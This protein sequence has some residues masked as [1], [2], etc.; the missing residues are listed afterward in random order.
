MKNTH[1][2]PKLLMTLKQPFTWVLGVGVVAGATSGLIVLQSFPEK[3]AMVT[4]SD[5]VASRL[6][7][8]QNHLTSLETAVQKPFPQLDLSV[9][10]QKIKEL[11]REVKD[12][13][14]FNPDA[15]SQHLE[16]RLSQTESSLSNQLNTL[17]QAVNTLKTANQSV[18]YLPAQVLPFVVTS[19]DSIQA[20]AVA[21]IAYD[22]KTVPVEKGDSLAGWKIVK[23]DFK[24]QQIEF[25]NKNKKRVLLKQD[26][27]G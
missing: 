26:H 22:Y 18:K 7:E 4:V 1:F 6:N 20:T 19:I 8:L 14:Q 13:R 17:N 10:E 25:E 16:V 2:L 15:L 5:A 3:N 24:H 21:T 9:L 11:S 12:I 27:I 23:V